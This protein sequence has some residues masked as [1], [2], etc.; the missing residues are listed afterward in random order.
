MNKKLVARMLGAILV[1]E[2][3]SM[4]PAMIIGLAHGDRT[5]DTVALLASALI[6]LACGLPLQLLEKPRSTN[7]RAREGFL[8]VTLSWLVMSVFGALPFVLSGFIPNFID[9]LF[10]AVS[11]FTTTG[12]SILH[13]LD[14]LPKCMIMW[15][16]FTHWIGGIGTKVEKL[17]RLIDGRAEALEF[18]AQAGEPYIGV[19]LKDLTMRPNSLVA[20]IVRRGKVIVPFGN[21]TIE[22]G[23]SVVIITCESGLSDLNEVIRK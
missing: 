19:P 10:E 1:I 20:V 4:V 17:Y 13:D 5:R 23:D 16:S 7:L 12:A 22:S 14:S 9:A 18:I 6:C 21:D 11:G 15:R 3:V 2:A 8:I